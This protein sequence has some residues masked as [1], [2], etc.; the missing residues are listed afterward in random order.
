MLLKDEDFWAKVGKG[1]EVLIA[2]TPHR[3]YGFD[4]MTWLVTGGEVV[5]VI[6]S[7]SVGC[8]GGDPPLFQPLASKFMP[9]YGDIQHVPLATV[10]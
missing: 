6:L 10:R 9:S 1:F 4:R 7:P 8:G 2:A 5:A 3:S